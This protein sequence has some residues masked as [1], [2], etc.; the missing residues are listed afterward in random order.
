MLHLDG[1]RTQKASV[2][3]MSVFNSQEQREQKAPN[4]I[5]YDGPQIFSQI[6]NCWIIIIT[7]III[8]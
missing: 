2:I 6:H 7:I 1:K 8:I 3:F 4:I 5:Y